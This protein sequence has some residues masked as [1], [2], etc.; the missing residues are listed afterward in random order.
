MSKNSGVG[1]LFRKKRIKKVNLAFLFIFFS[2]L[3]LQLISQSKFLS[4]IFRDNL[5]Y[6]KNSDS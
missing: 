6:S 1:G 3:T 5:L 4:I 2:N